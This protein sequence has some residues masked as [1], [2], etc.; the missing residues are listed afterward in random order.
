[1]MRILGLCGPSR[2]GVIIFLFDVQ[3]QKISTGFQ[4]KCL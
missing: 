4:E 2:S 3:I 1:M